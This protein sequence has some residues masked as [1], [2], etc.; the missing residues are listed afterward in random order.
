MRKYDEYFK[1]LE[2]IVPKN[3]APVEKRIPRWWR[4]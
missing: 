4:D 2:A 3:K 1:N